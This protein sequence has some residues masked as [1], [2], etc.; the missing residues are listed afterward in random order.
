MVHSIKQPPKPTQPLFMRKI[1]FLL[2]AILFA[3]ISYAQVANLISQ[4][5]PGIILIPEL[6]KVDVC[7]AGNNAKDSGATIFFANTI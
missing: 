4:C 1:Y 7:F 3:T 5:D 6:V 2:F